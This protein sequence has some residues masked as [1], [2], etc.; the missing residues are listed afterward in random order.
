[1]QT[2]LI[3]VFFFLFIKQK[4]FKIVEKINLAT[5][6]YLAERDQWV[7]L[8][9]AN[10]F[11]VI[12]IGG[13]N[14]SCFTSCNC[15]AGIFLP[16][17]SR[18]MASSVDYI[19]RLSA[20]LFPGATKSSKKQYLS[21][22][23][24]MVILLFCGVLT[25]LAFLASMI[26]YICRKNKFSGQTPSVSSDRESSWHSSANLINRKSSVSQSKISISSSVT[27]QP[28]HLLVS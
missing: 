26:C 5:L 22:K 25:S 1:M 17:P 7:C 15:A 9:P 16:Y 18:S 13:A 10:G 28:F 23:L 14:S 20:Y 2:R 24:V 4:I 8:C 27:G 11:P 3:F 19:I 21:R 6:S 12:A